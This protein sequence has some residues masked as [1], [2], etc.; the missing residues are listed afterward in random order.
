MGTRLEKCSASLCALNP[1]AVLIRGYSITF[2]EMG[3]A[4]L[5][6]EISKGDKITTMTCDGVIESVV[7]Q[8]KL[9]A[10]GELMGSSEQDEA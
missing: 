7:D 9:K 6:K 5:V 1:L 4:A 10:P 3:H 8:F 2:N